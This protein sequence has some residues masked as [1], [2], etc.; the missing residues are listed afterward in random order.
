MRDTIEIISG[1]NKNNPNTTKI[2]IA[3]VPITLDVTRI[4]GAEESFL[5]AEE[6][7]SWFTVNFFF[8][9]QLILRGFG[10]YLKFADANTLCSVNFNIFVSSSDTCIVVFVHGILV[11][12]VAIINVDI[13][14]VLDVVVISVVERNLVVGVFVD[15]FT[16]VDVVVLQTSL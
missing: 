8:Y 11:V 14:V 1:R 10:F 5:M 3:T 16:V 15:V 13:L 6:S 9:F 4:S 12:G 2:I 7:G